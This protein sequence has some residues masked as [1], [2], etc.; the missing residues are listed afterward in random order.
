MAKTLDDR[1]SEV[2]SII[3][4]PSFL[5]N[6]GLGNEVGY[7]VFDYPPEQELMVR[8]RIAE[9]KEKF[10]TAVILIT[11]DLGVVAEFCDRV[12]VV[13]SGKVVEQG[14]VEQI[15]SRTKNHPYTAGLLNCIPDLESTADRLIPIPGQMPDP[16]HLPQGCYF[17]ERC[18]QCMEICKRVQ[19]E[20]YEEDGHQ[21]F[22]H[23]YSRQEETI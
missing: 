23:L 7:Y 21:I 5:E 4:Q 1:L 17:A 10:N 11:H 12:V 18:G 13:Y 19:P 8:S 14:T 16:A 20:A 9:M 2:E 3:R 15:F 22:C 6:K